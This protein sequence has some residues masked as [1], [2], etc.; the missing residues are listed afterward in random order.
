MPQPPPPGGQNSDGGGGDHCQQ[1]L[2]RSA[3]EQQLNWSTWG[4]RITRRCWQKLSLVSF[5]RLHGSHLYVIKTQLKAFSSGPVWQQL[6]TENWHLII[7]ASCQPAQPAGQGGGPRHR[8]VLP[9]GLAGDE[10][11]HHADHSE[12]SLPQGPLGLQG[13]A[14]A[15]PRDPGKL[16]SPGELVLQVGTSTTIGVVLI[17]M[18]AGSTELRSS[19]GIAMRLWGPWVRTSSVKRTTTEPP[20][21]LWGVGETPTTPAGKSREKWRHL[22]SSTVFVEGGSLSSTSS[23]QVLTAMTSTGCPPRCTAQSAATWWSTETSSS[24]RILRRRSRTLPSP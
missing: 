8:S 19:L 3:R 12:A 2:V 16:H 4:L 11:R 23:T 6:R 13:Q 18:W 14:G 21:P 10:E 20:S 5:N 17:Q 22:P 15:V 24:L 1:P 7:S 9:A